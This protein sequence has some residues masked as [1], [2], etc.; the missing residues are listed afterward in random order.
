MGIK[1][2]KWL[3]ALGALGIVHQAS[4]YETQLLCSWTC[5]HWTSQLNY[6]A[7]PEEDRHAGR[8]T[9]RQTGR[10]TD[11]RFG[12]THRQAGRQTDRHTGR[13][14]GRQTDRQPASQTD[15]SKDLVQSG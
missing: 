3:E 8:Q 1:R 14:A 5:R 2:E 6:Q 13:Q 15:L 9:D 7:N 12:R 11:G 10:W 4:M